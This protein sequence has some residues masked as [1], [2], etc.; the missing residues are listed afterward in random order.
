MKNEER[1]LSMLDLIASEAKDLKE[2][3]VTKDEFRSFKEQTY[4]RFDRIEKNIGSLEGSVASLERSVASLEKGVACL[5]TRVASIEGNMII[6]D[7]FVAFA[8]ENKAEHESTNARISEQSELL[9]A[10]FDVLNDR[11]F[12]QETQ[13]RILKK[14][15]AL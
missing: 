4:D 3:S 6:K 14:K 1:I 12:N 13:L 7:E 15:E 9:E 11:L 8:K 2:T 10:R 5:E